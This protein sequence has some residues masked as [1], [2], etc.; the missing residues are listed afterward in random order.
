MIVAERTR[1][2]FATDIHGSRRCWLKFVNAAEFYEADVLVMGGDFTGKMIVPLV[3]GA[4]RKYRVQLSGKECDVH[5]RDLVA[6]ERQITD[7]GFYPYRTDPEEMEQLRAARERVDALFLQLMGERVREWLELARERL[8]PRGVRCFFGA[9]NDDPPEIDAILDEHAAA[10]GG[11][12][13]HCNDRVVRLTDRHEMVTVGTS[14][15]TPWDTPRETSEEQL[16]ARIDELAASV[17]DMERCVFNLHVPPDRSQLDDAPELDADLRPVTVGG[18]VTMTPVG[19]T[20]V[21]A[22]IERYQPLLA[23]HGHIHESKGF[24]KLGRTVCINPGSE[25]GDGILDGA[26]ID[27]NGSELTYTLVSG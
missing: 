13:V 17:S 21:R 26:V 6:V 23:L 25:D 22:S 24:T 3:R 9:G 14:N 10:S 8:A 4:K 20:A 2:Y 11:C 15:K 7:S 12:L 16:E 1:A 19:S 18:Q 27:L 5:E